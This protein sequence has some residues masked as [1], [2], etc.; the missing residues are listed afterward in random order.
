MFVGLGSV[1]CGPTISV[2]TDGA[3]GSTSDGPPAT[4]TTSVTTTTATTVNPTVPGDTTVGPV[5]SGGLDTDEMW[6]DLPEDCSTIEQDCPPGYK[7]MPW[8]SDGGGAW[9]DTRC[10]EIVPDPNAP[11]ETCSVEGSG[12]SGLDDCDGTSMCWD[13]DPATNE[14]TCRPFCIG[15]FENPTCAEPCDYCPLFGD[16][17]ITL[18]FPLCDPVGQDCPVGEACYPTNDSFACAPDA[19]ARD[20]QIGT[21][22]EFINGCPPGLMCLNAD[23][24]PDCMGAIGCCAPSCPVGRAD[25][26]PRLLPGSECVPW[27]EDGTVPPHVEACFTAE[28]GA[29]LIPL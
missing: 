25:P 16:G 8:A 17:N 5:D 23:S 21:P 19:S 27:Y 22:C 15:D 9:N 13:V 26:C 6:M 11:G 7:C 18:C 10:V 3:P 1:G 24:V 14:G 2:D 4:T 20:T 29:C 12:T 28:P